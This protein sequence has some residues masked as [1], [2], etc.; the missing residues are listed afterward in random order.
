[1]TVVV[2]RI[3]T[4]VRV[5]RTGE[6]RKVS[7]VNQDRVHVIRDARG[8]KGNPGRDGT[9]GRD[10]EDAMEDPGDMFVLAL[11]NAMV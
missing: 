3:T 1:M 8:P 6:G 9:D 5:E 2:S 7:V 10:G 11:E 4:G